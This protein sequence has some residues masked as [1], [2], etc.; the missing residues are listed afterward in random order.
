MADYPAKHEFV[1]DY[2]YLAYASEV[3]TVAGSGE[4][5]EGGG[6]YTLPVASADTLGGV[7]IGSGL[8]I[9]N[10]GVLSSS[11]S[12]VFYVSISGVDQNGKPIL[13]KKCTELNSAIEAGKKIVLQSTNTVESRTMTNT[14]EMIEHY[15]FVDNDVTNYGYTFSFMGGVTSF[16]GVNDDYPKAS[17]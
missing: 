15:S 14:S 11:G 9:D 8:A 7:K 2:P 12:D 5:G 16:E 1:D 13:A 6:S 3:D 4:G 17:R 10:N